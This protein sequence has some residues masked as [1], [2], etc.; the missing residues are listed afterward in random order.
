VHFRKENSYKK[1]LAEE[2][3]P[4]FHPQRKLEK[5]RSILWFALPFCTLAILRHAILK[6]QCHKIFDFC[7][8]HESFS[9]KPLR[10]PLGP[11][12]IFSKICGDIRSSG[13]TTGVVDTGGKRK[14]SSIIQVLII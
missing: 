8:F 3:S 4:L 7:F 2:N 11:F 1:N 13:C 12:Q 10:I 5:S 6:G 14:K 9:P